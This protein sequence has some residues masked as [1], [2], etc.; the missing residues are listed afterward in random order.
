MKTTLNSFLFLITLLSMQLYG[1]EDIK[2]S[3]IG[4]RLSYYDGARSSASFRR[5]G[6]VKIEAESSG[7]AGLS[8]FM[9]SRFS[10]RL[11]IEF[12]L[13]GLAHFNTSHKWFAEEDVQVF[14]AV[15]I[16]AGVRM[17]LLPLTS[18]GIIKPYI[19]AGAGG[20]ILSD[21]Q[22]EHE[23][24]LEKGTVETY[25]VGGGY[26]AAGLN[27]NFSSSLALNIEAKYHLVNF[28]VNHDRSGAEVGLGMVFMWGSWQP[29]KS[30]IS[31][32]IT[33]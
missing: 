8:F 33:D 30:D 3:G 6:Y 23:W 18:P 22:V 16:L 31:L 25:L 10:D 9:F 24:G 1:Q 5:T 12:S 21:V 27:I 17:D 19:A 29:A 13:G 7:G 14:A 32:N 11:S 4:F 15:P 2:S 28:D 26:G 20:Y